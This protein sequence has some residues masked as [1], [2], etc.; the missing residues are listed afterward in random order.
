MFQR[1]EV[2]LRNSSLQ[3]GLFVI[4]CQGSPVM[5]IRDAR[6]IRLREVE[7]RT[8]KKCS[9]KVAGWVG[10]WGEGYRN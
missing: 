2:L 7:A 1:C 3:M 6:W 4:L 9:I 5:K 8:L 10:I